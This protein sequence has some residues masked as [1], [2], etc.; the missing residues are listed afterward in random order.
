MPA[1]PVQGLLR[2]R[3]RSK[4]TKRRSIPLLNLHTQN[5]CRHGVSGCVGHAKDA[6]C[7]VVD[8]LA[9]DAAARSFPDWSCS[10]CCERTW[11][12]VDEAL[13]DGQID[14]ARLREVGVD[15][16]PLPQP[17][18]I[19]CLGIDPSTLSRPDADTAWDR[20][21]V[22]IAPVPKNTHAASPGWA[23]SHVILVPTHAGHGP[24]VWDTTRV[25]SSDLATEVAARQWRAVVAVVVARGV[26]PLMLGDRW[27]A[28]AP[29][30]ARRADVEASAL[31]RVTR[32]RVLSRPAPARVPGQ[33]GASR[34]DG[35]RFHCTDES[36]HGEAE[37]SWEG[38]DATGA[39]IEVR[40]WNHLHLRTARWVE[41]SVIQRS[42]HGATGRARDPTI[43]W[44]V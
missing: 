36:S 42:R 21:L 14:G 11:A 27:D 20:T 35:E 3:N 18:E 30:L 29:L 41:V 24:P 2:G 22:P 19:V 25:T 12:S 43:R 13:E 32:T 23:R 6:L 38:T 8:A 5:E 9:S 4:R 10:P 40:W 31:V 15:V 33:I 16:A 37:T 44:G 7:H 34:H 26:H 17:G 1:I 39:T 28:C